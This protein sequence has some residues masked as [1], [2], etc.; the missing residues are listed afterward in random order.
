MR[1]AA[2]KRLVH[3]LCLRRDLRE[4]SGVERRHC[5]RRLPQIETG[6][7]CDR[8]DLGALEQS[9][10]RRA[11]GVRCSDVLLQGSVD[12][13]LRRGVG[14][15]RRGARDRSNDDEQSNTERSEHSHS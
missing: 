4:F 14:S 13:R 3:P 2:G 7:R 5:A 12:R 11:I 6:L 8:L 10:H 1:L 15:L 9:Q